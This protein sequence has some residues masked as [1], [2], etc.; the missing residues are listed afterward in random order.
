MCKYF[1]NV[2]ISFEMFVNV[3]QLIQ[4]VNISFEICA[5]VWGIGNS[6]KSYMGPPWMPIRILKM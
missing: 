4:N 1:Q 3:F 2:N 6:C 5:N